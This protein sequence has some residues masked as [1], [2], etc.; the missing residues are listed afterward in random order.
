MEI[1]YKAALQA[2]TTKGYRGGKLSSVRI[3]KEE[4]CQVYEYSKGEN[5]QVYERCQINLTDIFVC[6]ILFLIFALV[7]I[8]SYIMDKKTFTPPPV[9]TDADIMLMQPNNVTFSQYNVSPIQENILTLITEAIQRQMTNEKQLS[10]DLFNQPYVDI[11]CDEAGGERNKIKV[12]DE[13]KDLMKKLFS[14]RWTHPQLKTEIETTGVIITAIHDVKKTNRLTLTINVWAIPF[15]I[16]YGVGVGGTM[17]NKAIALTLR[18]NYTKRI[19]KII[20]SQ[21]TR[22]KYDYS[23]EQFR[24]DMEIPDKYDNS[25][26]DRRILA[27]AQERIKE[28]GSDVW[29]DYKLYCKRPIKGRKPKD[30]S[31]LF[32]IHTL[33]PQAA[34]GEQGERYEFVYR[35]ISRAMKH[36]SSDRCLVAMNKII[37]LDQLKNVYERCLYYDDQVTAGKIVGDHAYNSLLKMLRE[38]YQIK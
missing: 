35:W 32:I 38:E 23:I 36:P 13:A 22:T 29:F 21:R 4:N 20:C 24:K 30:D 15:L 19:Y 2:F 28:S 26:I 11:I 6:L 17:F 25:N 3:F 12:V 9:P 5:C 34:G 10:R 18:G 27:P 37:E 14:F 31:I 7:I 8:K 1:S 33:N 16:Y